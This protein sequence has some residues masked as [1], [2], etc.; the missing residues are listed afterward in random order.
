MLGHNIEDPH[1]SRSDF[2]DEDRLYAIKQKLERRPIL[3]ELP[4]EG[5][6]MEVCQISGEQH[7]LSD[8]Q[9][10]S[11]LVPMR[12]G[13]LRLRLKAREP[14]EELKVRVSSEGAAEGGKLRM[15]CFSGGYAPALERS[16]DV[17]RQYHLSARRALRRAEERR[18]D[19]VEEGQLN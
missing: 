9:E 11:Y 13:V 18:N 16:T 8:L 4:E 3:N 14:Y 10:C 6:T 19:T 15:E 17:I 7:Q 2:M 1:L 12:Q 5:Q